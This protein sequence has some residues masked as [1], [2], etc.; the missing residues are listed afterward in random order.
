ML[1]LALLILTMIASPGPPDP[2]LLLEGAN[3]YVSAGSPPRPTAVLVL[4]GK[5]AFVGES[6]RA[7]RRAPRAARVD[8]TGSFVFPGWA[9]AHGHLAGLGRAL[10]VADLRGAADAGEAARR[11]AKIA[12]SLPAGNWAEG[13]GWDQNRW[14]GEKFPDARDLDAVLPDRPV[15]ARRVDGHAV[16]VNTAALRA[17]RIDAATPDPDGGRIVRRADGSASGVLVD[18]AMGLIE[19]VLPEASVGDFERR[20]LAATNACAKAGLTEV[21]DA[22]HYGPSE[23]AAL[24]KLADSGALPIRIYATVSNEAKDLAGFFAKGP[25]I[26]PGSDFL[27]VRAIKAL[28]DGALGSRGAALLADYS[29]DPGNRGLLVTPPE[30]LDVLA[31][32]AREKGWQLWIHA[33]GDRGNR[34]A[35]DAFARAAAAVPD[36]PAGGRR[37]RVEHAQILA[38]GDIPRFAREGVIAS[39]QPTHATSDMPWA[40]ARVGP[41]RIAGAYA[42]R[43]LKN[44]GARLAGGSDFPVESENPLLGFYAAVTR[45]DLDGKPPGGW[46][47][48]ERLTRREA[49]ALFTSDAAYAAFEEDRRG[50][51]AAGYEADLTVFA[52]D[53]MAAAEKEIPRIPVVLTLVGGKVAYGQ[54]LTA[55]KTP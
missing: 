2:G 48:E 47:R 8:L 6:A 18:R 36:A 12:A 17:A 11:I 13:R 28:A 21:Q 34:F 3:V 5:I 37:P 35:L 10:E 7:R 24:G 27:T 19:R 43:Q 42:W 40:E 46:R 25:R 50:R 44:A 29:D 14:P 9:D 33:I 49:L 22:S 55:G 1:F 26:G 15:V 53:P 23:I 52:R 51:I 41:E 54:G 4:D 31:R 32:Q 30:R 16:W 39:V 45:Q 38:L 20:I